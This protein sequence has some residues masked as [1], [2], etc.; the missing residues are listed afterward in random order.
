MVQAVKSGHVAWTEGG[1]L[2]G[3]ILIISEVEEKPFM[4]SSNTVYVQK[5]ARKG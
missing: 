1:G 5:P 2:K 4:S 3:E